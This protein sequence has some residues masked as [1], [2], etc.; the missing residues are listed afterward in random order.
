MRSVR[1]L[2]F[3]FVL[4][5]AVA[6]YGG[7]VVESACFVNDVS[8]DYIESPASPV[9]KIAEMPPATVIPQINSKAAEELIWALAVTPSD[10]PTLFSDLLR[11]I[12]VQRK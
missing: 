11:L 3:L 12:S 10:E 4:S 9:R 1:V 5:L 2:Q 6:L 7:E 8:N